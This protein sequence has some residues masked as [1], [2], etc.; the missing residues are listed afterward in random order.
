MDLDQMIKMAAAELEEAEAQFHAAQERVK[1]L[2]TIRDGLSYAK[3]R[4]GRQLVEPRPGPGVDGDGDGGGDGRIGASRGS[5]SVGDLVLD[6]LAA[7]GR[8]ASTQEIFDRLTAEGHPLRDKEQVR[9]AAG[10]LSR[11]KK[12]IARSASNP[13][14]WQT[15]V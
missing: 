2:E 4:Y 5:K 7:F 14:L 8:P 6:T 1:Q 13:N 10:Y 9:S 11:R 12:K 15:I 3:E